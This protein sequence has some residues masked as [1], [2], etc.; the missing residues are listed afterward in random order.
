M[1]IKIVTHLMPWEVDDALLCFDKFGQ[2]HYYLDKTDNVYF[3]TSLNLSSYLID[4]NNSQLSKQF[5]IDK[6]N[7]AC[8]A[9]SNYKTKHV[10]Y[11]GDEL[12]GHL[13]LQRN[14]VEPHIDFYLSVCPDT[15]FHSHLLHYLI[16]AAKQ[17]NDKYFLIT[18]EISQVWDNSWDILVNKNR[19]SI[20]Y[21]TWENQDINDI[22]YTL[23]NNTDSPYV[24]KIH[25]YKWAGWFDLYNKSFY[26]QLVPIASDWHGYGPWDLF[27]MTVC[28]IAKQYHK[29][30]IQQY[31]LRNQLIFDRKIGIYKNN[32]NPAIYKKYITL[33][34]VPKQR[35]EFEKNLNTYIQMWHQRSIKNNLL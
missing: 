20:D 11:D 16:A 34:D 18:P 33:K 21:A 26:E 8:A 12:Y 3:D 6:Y 15:Y 27:G 5:F 19:K 17:I 2:S 13:D 9:L 24:E 4:W 23:E 22:I 25:E 14:A 32:I 35:V 30:N 31:V 29:T 1:N 7:Y 10:I 28:N